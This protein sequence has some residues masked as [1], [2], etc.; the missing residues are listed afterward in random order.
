MHTAKNGSYGDK[1][2]VMNRRTLKK[3]CW[4]A[5]KVLI[6]KHGYQPSDFKPSYGQETIDAPSKMERRFVD[7]NWLNPGPL[8]GTPLLWEKVSYEYDEWEAKL[9]V[10]VLADIEHWANLSDADIKTMLDA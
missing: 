10:D 5:A 3:K 8:K 4:R 2:E 7:G 1:A 6:E 9:P